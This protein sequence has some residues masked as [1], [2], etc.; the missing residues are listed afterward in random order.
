MPLIAHSG[1]PIWEEVHPFAM[2]RMSKGDQ[3]RRRAASTDPTEVL[4]E[5]E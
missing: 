3:G 4:M 1:G 5:Q 2:L